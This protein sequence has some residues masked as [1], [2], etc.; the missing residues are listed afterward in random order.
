M[1]IAQTT[2]LKKATLE[3]E[4]QESQSLLQAMAEANPH[5]FYIYDLIEQQNIYTNRQL[6]ATLGYTSEE[7]QEMGAAFLSRLIHPDDFAAVA[8]HF[9]QFETVQDGEILEIEYRMRHKNGEYRWFYS[10]D[11]LF[12][13]TPEGKPKGILGTATDITKRKHIEEE[14][15]KNKDRLQLALEASEMGLWDWQIRTGEVY[16]SPQWKTMLGYEVGE[17]ENRLESWERLVHPDDL[18]KTWAE[19]T[20]YLEGHSQRYTLEFRM[21]SKSGEWRWILSQAK[22][23]E[24]DTSGT[25]LRVTGT[26]K[27]ISDQKWAELALTQAKAALEQQLQRILLQERITYEIRS[28]WHPEQF[29]QSAVTQIGQAFNVDRCLVHTYVEAPIP[30][31]P[32]VA[33]YKRQG[34]ESVMGV[35]IPVRGNPHAEEIL[36]HDRAIVVDNVYAES[37]LEPIVSLCEEFG[38]KSMLGVRTSYQGK[39]NGLI[40]VHQYDYFRH[41]HADEISL[42]EAVAA[43]LGI[44]IAQANLLEQERQHRWEL[45]R[46]NRQLQQEIQVRQQ[47]EEALKRS[48][49]R[50]QLVLKGNNDG[51]WDWNLKTNKAFRSPRLKEILGY[52]D[53]EISDEN[54]EWIRRIHP[55]DFERVMRTN[56]E[57]LTRKIPHYSIEYRL[58]CKDDDYKWVLSRAQAVWDE[59][60]NPVRMVASTKDISEYKK[61]QAALTASEQKYRDLVETSQDM[62]WSMDTEGYLTFVNS[63]VK[64]IYGYDP[65]E[66]I[67]RRFTDFKALTEIDQDLEAFLR[68]LKGETIFQY[69]TQHLAKNGKLIHLMINA[70]A[71]TDERSNVIGITGTASDITIRKQI[72]E[73]LRESETRYRELVEFQDQLL[74]CRW[75]PDTTLTFVN[76][77]YCRFLSQSSMALI[78]TRFLDWLPNSSTREQVMEFVRSLVDCLHSKTTEYPMVSATGETRWFCWTNQPLFNQ[79]GDFV[80]FQSF[81]IDITERKLAEEALRQSEAREREKAQ[82]LEIALG[83]LKRTQTQLLLSE[84][85]ASLGQLVAGVAH[86]INNPVGFIYTNIHPATGY[87]RGLL[88]LIELYQQYYPEPVTEITERLEELDINFIAEDFPKLLESMKMGSERITQIVMSLRNFSRL[89]HAEKKRVDIHEGINNTLFILQHRFKPK[90]YRPEIQVIKEYGQLPKVECYPGQL[91]QVFMNILNNAID[92]LDETDRG[93]IIDDRGDN[94]NQPLPIIRIHTSWLENHNIMIRISDNGVGIKTELQQKIFDPFFTTKPVGKGTGL[95]LSLSYQIVVDRHGGQMKCHSVVGQGTELT[96]EL[97]I[98]QNQLYSSAKTS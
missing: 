24:C 70:I 14:L 64:Q 75:N 37:L 31:I 72:Q 25:P 58:R 63:A 65:A 20:A 42:L 95:G 29:F 84:K 18:P 59:A 6:Q 98:T 79:A 61:A 96:I 27:D 21:R 46:Q 36:A 28:S 10:R 12:T 26:H 92:A 45:D 2:P 90:N 13:R 62:I 51:I 40:G 33:E 60:G 4:L 30:Q 87:A 94:A 74:V 35:E 57:Y 71:L 73:A 82:A 76:Q 49:E 68:L 16:F 66:M 83:Q 85:M 41:W 91:N 77:T 69:E 1:I 15:K 67:G 50:W 17:I 86:E 89:D 11:T 9:Q 39:P 38:L 22:V 3:E 54:D 34:M 5:V 81:G 55:D 47:T 93:E 88:H 52:A 7:I 53:W 23:M 48:E 56:L 97:P 19:V 32:L 8:T 44:A 43:Q 78:G 80:E